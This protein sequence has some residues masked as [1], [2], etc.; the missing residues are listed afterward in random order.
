MATDGYA[1]ILFSVEADFIGAVLDK[2]ILFF[3]QSYD[4]GCRFEWRQYFGKKIISLRGHDAKVGYRTEFFLEIRALFDEFDTRF[5]VIFF[6][7]GK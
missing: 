4:E 3:E 1:Q 7:L 6:V 5:L 2:N